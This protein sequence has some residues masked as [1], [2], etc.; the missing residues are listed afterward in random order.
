MEQGRGY[1]MDVCIKPASLV[2]LGQVQVD[3]TQDTVWLGAV[4]IHVFIMQFIHLGSDTARTTDPGKPDP[5]FLSVLTFRP[6]LQSPSTVESGICGAGRAPTF[7]L[8]L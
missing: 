2:I 1:V 5:S 3:Q 8:L 7:F 4:T 6:T